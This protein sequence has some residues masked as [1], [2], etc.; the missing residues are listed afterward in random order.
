MFATFTLIVTDYG[1]PLMV[2]GKYITV[3]VVMYQEVIGQLNFGKG[4]VY[5]CLLLIPAVGGFLIYFVY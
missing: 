1:V 5:G 4:A 3:P 2:G